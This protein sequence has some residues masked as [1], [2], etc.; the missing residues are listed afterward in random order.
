[1]ARVSEVPNM[2]RAVLHKAIAD[3][4]APL[5]RG[6]EAEIVEELARLTTQWQK[7]YDKLPGGPHLPTRKLL[8]YLLVKPQ[9]PGSSKHW[10]YS[11]PNQKLT[12]HYLDVC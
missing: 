11:Q 12:R 6:R 5:Y 2:D 8:V 7:M 1:M 10:H 4:L 3:D 9:T